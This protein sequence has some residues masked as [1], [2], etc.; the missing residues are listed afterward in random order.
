M[1]ETNLLKH[2]GRVF[3]LSWGDVQDDPEW[4]DFVSSSPYGHHEQTSLWGQVRACYGWHIARYM[5]QEDGRIVAG[6]QA[7]LRQAN[8]LGR[9]AYITYGPVADA[10]DPLTAA[11]SVRA[12]RM[13]LKR[14][15]VRAAVVGLPYDGGHLIKD[16]EKESFFPKPT[17]LP[18]HFLEATLVIDLAKGPEQLLVEMRASTRRNIRHGMKKGVNVQEGGREDLDTFR[19]LMEALCERRGITP[20]PPQADF[21]HRLWD[22]FA[23]RGWVRLFL[24]RYGEEPVCAALAFSF[25]DWFR[26]WKVG[27]SGSHGSLKPNEAMWW[28]MIQ[29][30]RRTGHRFFDF[31]ELDPVLARAIVAGTA[32]EPLPENVTSFKLGFGGEIRL[33]PGAYL[34]AANPLARLAMKGGLGR[35]LDSGMAQKLLDAYQRR[36]AG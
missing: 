2:E 7:M 25:G 10:R 9:G 20:N 11:A 34:Y 15:G 17:R 3:E 16:L 13:F 31:V 26:V 23:P 24:A 33:L 21:F 35:F 4:D 1:T 28:A 36:A 12:L 14:M 29:W 8:P 18:P 32:V 27:W 19:G 30:A 5:L 22:T 6:A